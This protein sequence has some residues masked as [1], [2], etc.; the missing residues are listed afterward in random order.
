MVSAPPF[1]VRV[2]ELEFPVIVSLAFPPI[3]FSIIVPGEITKLPV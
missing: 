3:A 1:P 2:F